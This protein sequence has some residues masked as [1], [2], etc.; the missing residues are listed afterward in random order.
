MEVIVETIKILGNF[1]EENL[2]FI[3]F[4]VKLVWIFCL[5]QQI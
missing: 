5:S 1:I 2:K 4:N 3:E